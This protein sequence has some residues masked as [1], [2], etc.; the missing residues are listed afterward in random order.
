MSHAEIRGV[1]V[2]VAASA[3]PRQSVS[4]K[5]IGRVVQ[6]GLVSFLLVTAV[7]VEGRSVLL[8]HTRI[9]WSSPARLYFCGRDYNPASVVSASAAENEMDGP[10]RQVARGPWW[11]PVYGHPEDPQVRDRLGVPCAMVLYMREGNGYRSYP[12]SGGP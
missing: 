11:Q 4:R 8:F 12:L 1:A 6:L 2:T 7:F 9:P 3:A 10:F 5:R